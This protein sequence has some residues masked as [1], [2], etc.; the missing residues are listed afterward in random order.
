MSQLSIKYNN[1]VVCGDFNA[2]A[3]KFNHDSSLNDFFETISS[4]GLLPHI[5]LPT[6]FGSR[7]GSIIDQIFIKADM[8]IEDIHSGILLHEFS[9]HLPVFTCL[10]LKF[11]KLSLPK[12]ISITKNDNRSYE[13]LRSDLESIDWNNELESNL[14]SNPNYNYSKF[15]DTILELK[16]KH[17]PT[18][19][20]RFKRY[21]HKGNEWI[22]RGIMNS[23]KKKDNLYKKFR[24]LN[25]ND[26][27]Y[28][29]I[30]SFYKNYEKN[31]KKLIANVKKDYYNNKFHAYKNNIKRTF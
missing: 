28:E 8:N 21:K 9:H 6:H 3:L 19:T 13:I 12:F 1:I 7:N 20:V 31:L 18:K 26:S 16:E 22:T 15:K 17:L 14:F 24:S 11:E 10:P 27:N 29:T 5:T 30:K 2:D 23:I 4:V 25:Q